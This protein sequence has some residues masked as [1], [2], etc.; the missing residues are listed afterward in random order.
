MNNNRNG[1]QKRANWTQFWTESIIN[2][3]EQDHE[4][5]KEAY[6]CLTKDIIQAT[7]NTI[8]RTTL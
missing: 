4:S 8:P 3:K 1:E 5:I 7:E 2:T 6:S